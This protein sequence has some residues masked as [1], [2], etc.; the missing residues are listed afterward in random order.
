MNGIINIITKSAKETHG[1]ARDQRRRKCRSRRRRIPFWRDKREGVRL[2]IYGKGFLR[3]PEFHPDGSNFD[4][5]KTGQLG[6]RTDW[7][8]TGR[9]SFTLQGDMYKG[10][11]GERVAVSSY[12]PP[13]MAIVD[14]PHN[15]SGGNLLGR[16]RRKFSENSDIQIQG[17][18][19]RTS[20]FSPQLDRYA[21]P[22]I[23]ICWTI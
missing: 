23:L 4:Y 3:G 7:D 15:V 21:I 10:L 13:S 12:S 1:T 22:M 17:Y 19:D 8:I 14:A 2:R 16:W 20:R 5:W 9:D 6:F 11:D 18:Y